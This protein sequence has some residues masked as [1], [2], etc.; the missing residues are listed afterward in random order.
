MTAVAIAFWISAGLLVYAQGGYGLLL[1]VLGRIRRAG[2]AHD[3]EPG[4]R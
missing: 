2:G 4:R 1:A 3:G